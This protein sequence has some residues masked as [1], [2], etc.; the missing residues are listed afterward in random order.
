MAIF[1]TPSV[2]AIL[3]AFVKTVNDLEKL[4]ETK[5]I[6][7]ERHQ[8]TINEAKSKKDAAKFEA[9]RALAVSDKITKLISE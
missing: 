1:K 8:A 4:A 6:E 5:L 9:D 2:D 7:V 3:A